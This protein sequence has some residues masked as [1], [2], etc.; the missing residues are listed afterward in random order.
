MKSW[1]P[2]REI[3]EEE[4]EKATRES[5]NEALLSGLLGGLGGTVAG[6]GIPLLAGK[7]LKIGPLARFLEK[8]KP[9]AKNINTAKYLSS[10]FGAPAG[11]L[12]GMGRGL[13]EGSL[14]GAVKSGIPMEESAEMER[15]QLFQLMDKLVKK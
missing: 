10:L 15:Q 13:S 12:Y 2:G 14:A 11:G 9:L 3:S 7:L 5:V 4:Y 6:A 1:I 8:R